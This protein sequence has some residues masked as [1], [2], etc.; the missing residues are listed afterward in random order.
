MAIRRL[1][2]GIR[3]REKKNNKKR[4]L[5]NIHMKRIPEGKK[6]VEEREEIFERPGTGSWREEGKDI[7]L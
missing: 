7:E 3:D 4:Y 1:L 2:D 5:I 6:A